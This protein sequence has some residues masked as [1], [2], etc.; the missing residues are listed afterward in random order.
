MTSMP[1]AMELQQLGELSDLGGRLRAFRLGREWT[2]DDLAR[3]VSLS[4]SYL[5]RLEEGERQ[6]SLASLLALSRAFSVPLAALLQEDALGEDRYAG[7]ITRAAQ[8]Q[9]QPG[10]GLTYTPLSRRTPPVGMQPVRVVVSGD[11]VG[12]EQYQHDGEEWLYVLSGT[13]QLTLTDTTH[14]LQPG[15]AAHFDA[16]EPHRLSALHSQD[17]ELI[18]VACAAPRPLLD[19]YRK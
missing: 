11:R 6:P 2:L 17:A 19:S 12:E 7:L 16:R 3:K 13:L 18:V 15:D 9:P 10:N 5:S 4:K 1:E 8:A 14:I